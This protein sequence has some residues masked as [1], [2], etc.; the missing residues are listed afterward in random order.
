MRLLSITGIVLTLLAIIGCGGSDE[1]AATVAPT[2]TVAAPATAT[3]VPPTPSATLTPTPDPSPTAAATATATAVV[4]T[5]VPTAV[6]ATSDCPQRTSL[7]VE[8]GDVPPNV[9]FGSATI[10]GQSVP[11]GTNVTAC[12]DDEP[13]ASASLSD[14]KFLLTIEQRIPTLMGKTITFS[15]GGVDAN[16][17][18]V[19]KQGD[20]VLFDLSADR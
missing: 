1:P 12:I 18:A 9:F 5:Q 2:A 3:S 19:W 11:D 15:V 10:D 7:S 17:T 6:P 13:V 20:A 14:G 16:E 4:P 8:A